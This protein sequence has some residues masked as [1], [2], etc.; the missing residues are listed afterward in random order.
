MEKRGVLIT[1][2]IR[3]ENIKNGSEKSKFFKQLYGWTQTVPKEKK[4]YSYYREGVL[5]EVPHVKVGQSSF[6]VQE[7]SFDRIVDFFEEWNNKVMWRNFKILLGEDLEREF[8]EFW[9]DE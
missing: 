7:D 3:T 6:V 5:D 1:F 4:T 8:E 2:S 9:E